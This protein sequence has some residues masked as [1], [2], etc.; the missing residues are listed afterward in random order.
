MNTKKIVALVLV[1]IAALGIFTTVNA[2]A[3]FELVKNMSMTQVHNSIMSTES[4]AEYDYTVIDKKDFD[5]LIDS[6]NLN[7]DGEDDILL[8]IN[9]MTV[10]GVYTIVWS[11]TN[12]KGY[13]YV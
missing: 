6:I 13:L 2:E 8:C 1:I 11:P 12:E 9:V 4:E 7:Y 5:E 3:D 10:D